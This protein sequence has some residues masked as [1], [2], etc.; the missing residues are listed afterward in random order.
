[1]NNASAHGPSSSPQHRPVWTRLLAVAAG[2]GAIAAVLI[3]LLLAYVM[4]VA[5]PNLP[6]IDALTD[7]RPKMPLRVYTADNV[8]LGEFGEERRNFMPINQI[9]DVMK[10]AVLAIE[11]DRFYEHGGVDY[12]G[13]LRAGV[14]NLRGNLSQGASTITMQV[15]RNFFLSRE[16]TFTRKIYEVLLAWK[17][18]GSL[19]KDQIL[20]LYMNQIYLG[21][22]AYG[23]SSAAQIYFGKNLKDI[24]VAEAAM[25]AGLP[26]APS[27]YNPVVNP[28]RART[29]QLYILQRM[30][31]LKYITPQQYEQ[32]VAE[33]L[34]IRGLGNEF[35]VHA[36]YVAEMVRQTMYEQYKDALYTSGISV[37][38]TITKADQDAAYAALRR[39]VIDY[40][41]RHGYRGPEGFVE[42]P[43]NPDERQQVI[44]DALTDHPD[45]DDLHSAV[46][47]AAN[48]KQVSAVLLNGTVVTLSGEGLRFGAAAL[49]DN[50]QPKMKIRPGA[51]I[52]V[53]ETGPGN[54]VLSQQP[55]VAAAFVSVNSQDWRQPGSSFKPFIYSAALEKGFSP[56]T[57]VNDAPLSFGAAETGGQA[58]EPK[59]YDGKYEGPMPLRRAL[60]RSKNMVSIRVL[61]AIGVMGGRLRSPRRSTNASA[62]S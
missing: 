11:D 14:A 26:K 9:P 53:V 15:A 61:R 19:S 51:I 31:D 50:A 13:V 46:V 35:N 16:K 8:L 25:L 33:K 32:A 22:R 30:R 45:N 55:E 34:V 41:R 10:H 12:W 62:R 28:Q 43:S 44:D 20:E 38:T 39:G 6:S 48:P 18:E 59:N 21:Q 17:I 7:Y 49:A 54:W 57:V 29:R 52:R 4:I 3:V 37:Y 56:A 27:A 40:E 36:E 24:T 60:A 58:W 23:F 5:K 42:L 1:M 2:L 47:L